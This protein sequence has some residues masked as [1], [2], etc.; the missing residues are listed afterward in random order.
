MFPIIG[1]LLLAVVATYVAYLLTPKPKGPE[2]S[3][4]QDFDIPKAEEG[5]E[6]PK[7]FGTVEIKSPSVVWYGDLRLIAIKAKGKK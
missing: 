6:I 4:L 3:T 1:R 2:P 7:V 5:T